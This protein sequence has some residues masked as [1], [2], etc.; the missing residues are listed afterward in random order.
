MPAYRKKRVKYRFKPKFYIIV[1]VLALALLAALAFIIS[2]GG[3]AATTVGV[4]QTE[5]ELDFAIIRNEQVVNVDRYDGAEYRV[6]EGSDVTAG[7]PLACVYRWGYSDEMM[8]ALLQI[9]E[10]IYDAQMEQLEGISDLGLDDVNNRIDAVKRRILNAS[11]YGGDGDVLEL[12]SELQALLAERREY[13]LTRVQS[14]EALLTLY[15]ERET[16][17]AQLDQWRSDVSAA[18]DGRVSFYFDG[19]EQSLNAS[20]LDRVTEH[21]VSGAIS[22]ASVTNPNADSE[23][24]LYRIV[25]PGVWY[26]AFLTDADSVFRTVEGESYEVSFVGAE[27]MTYLGVAQRPL[28]S[29]DKFINILKFERDIG[30]FIS[31]RSISGVMSVYTT[32]VIVAEDAVFIDEDGLPYVRLYGSDSRIYV[33]VLASDGETAAVRAQNSNSVL[34]AGQTLAAKQ[35]NLWQM[36]FGGE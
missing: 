27:D 33:D 13:L 35:K 19:Y 14:T 8:Q 12:E 7:T 17:L 28:K 5:T 10:R 25:D 2:N 4:L 11:M 18:A 6:R 31:I 20:K 15:E 36:I 29:D 26:C 16:R 22:G 24:A 30:R 3:R 23:S 21:L 34:T 32:G 1:S 9:E